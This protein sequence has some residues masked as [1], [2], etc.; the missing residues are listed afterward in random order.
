MESDDFGWVFSAFGSNQPL[1]PVSPKV[2]RA[3]LH[4][5]YDL[6]RH[7][8]PRR[9]AQA[10]FEMLER[11]VRT[12]PKFAK[13][14]GITTISGPSP[15]SADY[16]YTL[17]E[18]AEKVRGQGAYWYQAQVY[19]DRTKQE[20]GVDIKTSDNRYPCATKVLVTMSPEQ[21]EV[22]PKNATLKPRLKCLSL[23]PYSPR[24]LSKQPEP[25]QVRPPVVPR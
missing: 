13:L 7:D 5:S 10:D 4:R 12:G 18:V 9:T 22:D 1:N 3:L 6:V 16:P 14:F 23:K 19:L 17:S 21:Y 8:I 2:L 20:K 25:S 11:T 24:K 15:N